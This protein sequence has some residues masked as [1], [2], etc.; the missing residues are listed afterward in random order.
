MDVA[1]LD[2]E[3]Y[4]LVSGAGPSF[5]TPT[6]FSGV[7]R[8]N[9]DGTMTLAAD[10][11][12]WLPQ[13]P[14]KFMAPDAGSDG[15]LFDLEAAGDSLVLSVADIGVIIRVTPATGEIATVAD[16]SEGHL[17]PDGL[18]VDDQGNIYVGYETTPP[19]PVGGSKVTE[20]APDGTMTDVWTGLTAMT[21]IAFGPD[22]KLYA[23]EMATVTSDT[24][25]ILAPDTGK[26]VRQT[27]PDSQ[28]DVVTG[29]PYPVGIGFSADGMLVFDTP[30]FGP[31]KGTGLGVLAAVDPA[32]AP[33]AYDVASSES[34]CAPA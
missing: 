23:A 1:F 34:I 17:V 26:I 13:H 6:A 16:L 18:A 15:S 10:L 32:N 27:G 22:G 20:I 5:L 14:P 28:E 33:I 21:D 31:N 12:T 30:A 11:T 4:V 2:G 8:L 25:P 3:P 29:L 19:Y 9:P 24:D 7:F